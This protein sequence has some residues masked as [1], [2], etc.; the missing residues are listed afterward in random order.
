MDI[1]ATTFG[2]SQDAQ[3]A[4]SGPFIQ[5]YAGAVAEYGRGTTFM[6]RFNND[7]YAQECN[8]NLYYPFAS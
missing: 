7:E 4:D 2:G 3:N 5:E 8:T 1:N 6:D